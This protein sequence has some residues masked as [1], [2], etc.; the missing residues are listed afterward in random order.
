MY[1]SS[2]VLVASYKMESA[3]AHADDCLRHDVSQSSAALL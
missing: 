1:L 3:V 2:S